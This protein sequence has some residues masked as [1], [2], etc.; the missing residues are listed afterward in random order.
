MLKEMSG[1]MGSQ[2]FMDLM[3]FWWVIAMSFGVA[4]VLAFVWIILL[5]YCAG[6]LN[7]L[8]VYASV[9]ML[10]VFGVV[11]QIQAGS[12]TAPDQMQV[13]PAM[14][15][16]MAEVQ[17]DPV[18]AQYA[19]YFCYCLAVVM[20]VIFFVFHDR[21]TM[22]IGVIEEASDCFLAIPQAVLLPIFT[23]AIEVPI[24]GYLVY[25][26]LSMLSMREYDPDADRYI[27]SD[28][29]KQMV[30]FNAFGLL[31]TMYVITSVQYTTIAGACADW[32]FTFPDEDG[33]RDVQMFAVIRS[34][35]RVIRFSFGTMVFGALLIA[36]VT[37]AKYV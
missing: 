28:E 4:L 18:Y 2:H 27:Y 35:D 15:E 21:I 24:V 3:D 1:E 8:T 29:L 33:D 25:S 26:S 20:A 36:V 10:P 16:R 5:D 22:S 37:V 30:A 9:L 13:P 32:Y 17:L 7:W 23:F 6:P 31:W 34:L 19:A 11:L 12:L 14:Q